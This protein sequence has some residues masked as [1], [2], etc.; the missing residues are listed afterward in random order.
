[1]ISGAVIAAIASYLLMVAAFYWHRLRGFHIPVMV[2]IIVFDLGMP[3]YLILN[4]DWKT[5]LLDHGDILS[6]GLWMH[7]GLL[8]ALYVLYAVQ[9]Q[10]A[11]K[12]V[13]SG[14]DEARSAHASQAKGIMLV[15]ALVIFTGAMLADPGD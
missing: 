14:D 5:R 1:V 10:S 9:V 6:F 2:A 4:R 8:I 11:L 13:A 7:F 12:L 15:R 3:V